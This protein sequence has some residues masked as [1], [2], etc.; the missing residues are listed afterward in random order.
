MDVRGLLGPSCG[1]DVVPGP[2]WRFQSGR[3]EARADTT[4]RSRRF[5]VT[6]P[7]RTL[8]WTLTVIIEGDYTDYG[9]AV[10]V[11]SSTALSAKTEIPSVP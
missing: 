4:V 1:P 5:F 2:T 10:A 11:R 6:D 8:K 7:G 9:L 3:T